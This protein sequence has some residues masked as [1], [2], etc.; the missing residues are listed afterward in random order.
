VRIELTTALRSTVT[1]LS[2]GI[3]PQQISAAASLLDDPPRSSGQPYDF[4]RAIAPVA[5][6]A[7][8]VALVVVLMI[9]RAWRRHALR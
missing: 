5:A 6:I 3:D 2:E 8:L 9:G 4:T 7:A 1:R